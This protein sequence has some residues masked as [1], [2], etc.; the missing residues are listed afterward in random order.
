MLPI[1]TT[2]Q[3]AGFSGRALASYSSYATA[4]LMQAT[5]MFT[6]QSE[7]LADGAWAGLDADHQ[8]LAT[9]GILAMADWIYLR[10]P[11]QQI[12]ASPLMSET[13][14]SYS[15]SK[16]Q[17]EVARNA[18]ALEVT[19]ERTGV[20]LYDLALQYIALRTLAGGIVSGGISVFERGSKRYDGAVLNIDSSGNAWVSGPSN[21]GA[22]QWPG[23]PGPGYDPANFGNV[24]DSDAPFDINAPMFPGDP[25]V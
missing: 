18:A 3:L 4:A 25:G 24:F 1:P 16:S 6:F 13:V 11:Y 19:G 15:Y 12:I 2:A 21:A 23:D 8:S 7:L 20:P 22:S 14:G 10:Q 5:L 17:Q 9:N